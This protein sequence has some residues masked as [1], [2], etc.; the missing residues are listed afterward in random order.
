ML[1]QNRDQL[2]TRLASVAAEFLS[3]D[4]KESELRLVEL[5]SVKACH[6]DPVVRELN[7]QYANGGRR[8]RN[9]ISR[10]LAEMCDGACH[11][12]PIQAVLFRQLFRVC[13]RDLHMNGGKSPRTEAEF[14]QS[15][16]ATGLITLGIDEQSDQ[17]VEI[18]AT[19]LM[20]SLKSQLALLAGK[21]G[22]LTRL[23]ARRETDAQLIEQA[24]ESQEFYSH[25]SIDVLRW[26]HDRMLVE[27]NAK[28]ANSI[29]SKVSR[30]VSECFGSADSS[31][32]QAI[33]RSVLA[34]R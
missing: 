17:E 22:V 3:L 29:V 30:V 9:Y 26:M 18:V 31:T 20:D 12:R 33:A 21:S 15:L 7:I 34:V 4:K 28:L 27:D 23:V 10:R 6:Q 14:R 11:G 2:E 19:E 8:V 13:P 5:K 16:A 32:R 1:Q 25:E 24:L